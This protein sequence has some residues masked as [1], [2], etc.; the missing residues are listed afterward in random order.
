M[1]FG[2]PELLVTLAQLSQET[3]TDVWTPDRSLQAL[4]HPYA[5]DGKSTPHR[6]GREIVKKNTIRRER[7]CITLHG[8]QGL[9]G[10]HKWNH[11]ASFQPL[12]A[13]KRVGTEKAEGLVVNLANAGSWESWGGMGLCSGA[14]ALE[15]RM[16]ERHASQLYK[17]TCAHKSVL[18]YHVHVDV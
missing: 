13:S 17:S 16:V 9:S 2:L 1:A 6:K 14:S 4:P 11:G 12:H 7:G 10:G 15:A 3:V 8:L 5:C 18:L